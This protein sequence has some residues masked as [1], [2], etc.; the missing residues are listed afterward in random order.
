LQYLARTYDTKHIFTFESEKEQ[1]KA[2]QWNSFA[3]GDLGQ[4]TTTALKY[5]RFLPVRHAF[6]T[7]QSHREMLRLYSVLESALQGKEYLVGDKYSIADMACWTQVNASMFIGVGDLSGWPAL[8]AWCERIG[9]R[10]AVKKAMS[11]PFV[12]E[13]GNS[14]VTKMLAEGGGFAKA[15]DGL[16]TALRN[17]L[18]EFSER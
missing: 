10:E 8:E 15:N 3:Q 1:L 14:A 12:T 9:T 2:D 11:V 16:Q 5:Y 6:P 4:T 13:Y 7:A 18:K 17:A